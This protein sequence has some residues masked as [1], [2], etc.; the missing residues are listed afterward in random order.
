MKNENPYLKRNDRPYILKSENFPEPKNEDSSQQMN[1]DPVELKNEDPVEI[2]KD[3]PSEMKTEP[4]VNVPV[5]RIEIHSS[6][7][8]NAMDLKVT[9][10]VICSNSCNDLNQSKL[11]MT[12]L[13]QCKHSKSMD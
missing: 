3:Y 6:G 12:V 13:D 5:K 9:E 8:L 4:I 2:L 1:E 7:E 11:V 10:L